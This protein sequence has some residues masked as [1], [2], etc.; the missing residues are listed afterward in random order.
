MGDAGEALTDR[1]V[2]AFTASNLR[3][4]SGQDGTK[5]LL[6]REYL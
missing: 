1:A 2:N 4:D 6:L 3:L 5:S